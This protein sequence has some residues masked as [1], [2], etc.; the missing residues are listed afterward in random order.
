[1]ILKAYSDLGTRKKNGERFGL[2]LVFLFLISAVQR[3]WVHPSGAHTFRQSDTIGYCISFA[4]DLHQRGLA[5]LDF[6]FYPKLL[7][8]GLLDGVNAR[9]FPLLDFLGGFFFLGRPFIGLFITSALLLAFNFW[10]AYRY[11]PRLL[12]FFKV[13]VSSSMALV[14]WF[15]TVGV[16]GQSDV[17]MP[18]GLGFPM[19]VLGL[20]ELLEAEGAISKLALGMALASIGIAIKPTLVVMLGV[21]PFLFFS[22]SDTRKNAKK[23]IFVTAL[24]LVFPGWWYTVHA[25][26]IIGHFQGPQVAPL[27]H[28]EALTK[29]REVGA[30]GLGRLLFKEAYEDLFPM[31][32]GWIFLILGA[33]YGEWLLLLFFALGVAFVTS[34]DGVHTFTHGYYFIGVCIF[35]LPLMARVL[36]ASKAHRIVHGALITVLF[37]GVIYNIRVNVWVW[38]R[39][40]QYWQVNL[41]KQGE[42]ARGL[43]PDQYHVI[44]DES[45]YP[46]R[47]LFVGRSGSMKSLVGRHGMIIG[48][49]PAPG[50]T[51]LTVFDTCTRAEYRDLPL[52]IVT[53]DEPSAE[54]LAK[55]GGRK[56]E[57]RV[58]ESSFAKWYITLADRPF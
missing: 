22:D 35:T 10:V 41:W 43:I 9:E 40:S 51:V 6:L 8:R 29:L 24:A 25:R 32:V 30:S 34:L 44:T 12:R 28:L 7:Q 20:V 23:L 3:F 33:I 55:C 26:E 47:L 5:A 27:G 16:A 18:E 48:T 17:I 53:V 1:M 50:E 11:L 49:T 46:Q 39:D 45:D 21:L 2:F 4:E 36:S 15:C 42:I 31:F 14:L 13:T 57:R 52:A 38:A 56:L 54:L 37:W 19:I 58:A